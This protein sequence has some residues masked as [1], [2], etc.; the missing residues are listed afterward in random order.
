MPVGKLPAQ[1][2]SESFAEDEAAAATAEFGAGAASE[3]Q[4]EEA[5]FAAGEPFHHEFEAGRGAL[6]EIGD[7]AREVARAVPGLKG[8]AR[9][10]E[11]EGEVVGGEGK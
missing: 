7:A 5:A 6:F 11:I 9:A 10:A 8:K 4:Q 1:E 2:E 3:V